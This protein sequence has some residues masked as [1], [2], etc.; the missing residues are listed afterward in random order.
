MESFSYDEKYFRV[1]SVQSHVVSGYV[2]NKSACFPLQLL[3]CEVDFINS[4]QF[5]NHT[6]YKVIKGQILKSEELQEL[7]DGL[8]A[9]ELLT[10]TH[11]LTGYVGNVTFLTKLSEII[12]DLKQINPSLFVVCDPVMGDNGVMYVPPEVLPIY[13]DILI[14]LSDLI[15]PNQYEAELLTGLTI[16][17]IEDITKVMNIF[18]EKGVKTVIL[19]SVQLETSSNLHLFGSSILNDKKHFVNMEIKKLPAEFTGTGDLF[20]ALLLA[21]MAR[22]DGDLKVSCE[23]A[24]N[25]L[26]CVLKRTIDYAAKVGKSVA[27]M[28]LQL[29]RSK[30]DI[31]NPPSILKCQDL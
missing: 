11:V 28:E 24:V 27:T 3:G 6:G 15:T 30:S 25:S 5:S 10:Y 18:H 1:L 21:W 12:K 17:S 9:N 13:R 2:G 29:I 22:T 14:P 7:Y 23:N 8:K 26:Q 31:E 16:K 19:S 20:S 4:V